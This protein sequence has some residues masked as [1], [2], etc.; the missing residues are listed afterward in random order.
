MQNLVPTRQPAAKQLKDDSLSGLTTNS[1][2]ESG[3]FTSQSMDDTSYDQTESYELSGRKN[4]KAFY[5]KNFMRDYNN[6]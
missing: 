3:A 5:S 2:T 6:Y 4:I 1:L